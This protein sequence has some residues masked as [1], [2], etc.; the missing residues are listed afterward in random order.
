VAQLPDSPVG[1]EL[2]RLIQKADSEMAIAD[3]G[4]GAR[5]SL[6]PAVRR[7]LVA[8]RFPGDG[9]VRIETRPGFRG[10]DVRLSPL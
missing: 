2:A 10:Q 1:T 9:A 6:L 5:L 3:P 8:T 7:S 4:Q